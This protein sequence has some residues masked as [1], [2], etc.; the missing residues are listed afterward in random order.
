[1]LNV[2][3]PE[4]WPDCHVEQRAVQ[5]APVAPEPHWVDGHARNLPQGHSPS[6]EARDQAPARIRPTLKPNQ[7]RVNSFERGGLARLNELRTYLSRHSALADAMATSDRP[8]T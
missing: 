1:M 2:A 4:T 8:E 5:A 3:R 7:T 6:P